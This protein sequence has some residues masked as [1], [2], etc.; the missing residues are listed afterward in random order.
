MS[1]LMD[2]SDTK[3][4]R[5]EARSGIYYN[6]SRPTQ[7]HASELTMENIIDWMY[8][9]YANRLFCK[10]EEGTYVLA[11][12]G[13]LLLTSEGAPIFAKDLD[14]QKM[15]SLLIYN[16]VR[17]IPEQVKVAKYIEKTTFKEV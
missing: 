7:W 11:S 1:G 5:A 12:S 2:R 6:S 14:V 8:P 17:T 10:T 16:S 9:V 3:I 13:E 15:K 4:Y